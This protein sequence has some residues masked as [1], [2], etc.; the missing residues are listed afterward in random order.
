[1]L[2]Y[3]LLI[4][5]AGFPVV[6]SDG[7]QNVPG[8]L[9]VLGEILQYDDFVNSKAGS[10]T[11]E[12]FTLY[13][14]TTGNDGNN[15]L[16]AGTACLTI[17]EAVNRVP[18]KV[19][20]DVV[21]NIGEGNFAGFT[22]AGF[23][24]PRYV[25]TLLIK[26]TLGNPTLG[27]GTVSGT[28]DAGSTTQCVDNAG[29][30]Q[31]WVVNELRGRLVLVAG[32]YRVIR[33]NTADTMNLIGPLSATC[34]GKAYE[35]FEQKTVIN[36]ASPDYASANIWVT[37]N[38]AGRDNS[39]EFSDLKT[40]GNTYAIFNHYGDGMRWVRIHST[41][42]TA[43]ILIQSIGGETTMEDCYTSGGYYGF[44]IV[45]ISGQLRVKRNYAYSNTYGYYLYGN[46]ALTQTN[47]LYSDAASNAGFAIGHWSEVFVEDIFAE[48]A[49]GSGMGIKLSTNQQCQIDGLT[50]TSNA[51][52]GIY[53]LG[54]P[55]TL[56]GTVNISSNGGYGIVLGGNIP[57]ANTFLAGP[58]LEIS[59]TAT[60]ATN[61]SGGILAEYDSF[62]ILG[63][64]DGA[65]TGAYGLILTTG[66][67]AVVTSSTGITGATN[68]ATINSGNT[69]LDW[70]TDFASNGDAVVNIDN[71]CRIERRD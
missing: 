70:S 56:L 35:I 40:T 65:N 13:V 19:K 54:T 37:A 21:I 67:S 47:Y 17:Q 64:V 49:T 20:H 16:T 7:E 51:S 9:K 10:E 29:P 68:D 3:I 22:V 69:Q 11:V 6:T 63:D 24:V 62:V 45:E 36:S 48:D 57:P 52:T 31:T 2:I 55:L 50:V 71:G 26:G 27:G 30:G 14:E 8:N 39:I 44:G 53:N 25:G 58:T 43:N 34:N 42:A 59:G 12:D 38:Q 23:I 61:T 1:M 33:D 28:A 66:S 46:G 18:T 5:L 32:E 41:G 4:I 15:C 60:I